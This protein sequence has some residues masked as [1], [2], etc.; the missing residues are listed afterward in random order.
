MSNY[1][2]P[3]YKEQLEMILAVTN[4]LNENSE[5]IPVSNDFYFKVQLVEA[6]EGE[7]IGEWSDEVGPKD[8][9]FSFVAPKTKAQSSIT[10]TRIRSGSGIEIS[11]EGIK[12]L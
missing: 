10:G 7:V 2:I 6:H 9:D 12:G 4:M 3:L 8:W 1:G 5:N 11:S